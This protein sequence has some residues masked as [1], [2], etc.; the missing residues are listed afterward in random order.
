MMGVPP[1]ESIRRAQQNPGY[2]KLVAKKKTVAGGLF[3]EFLFNGTFVIPGT[4]DPP[5]PFPVPTD[6]GLKQGI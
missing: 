2:D 3:L 4:L 6:D 1:F 5:D